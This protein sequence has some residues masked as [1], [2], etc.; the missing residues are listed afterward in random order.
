L[1][2]AVESLGDIPRAQ[3]AQKRKAEKDEVVDSL[4][5]SARESRLRER[6][7][8]RVSGDSGEES[9]GA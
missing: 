1:V 2:D 9:G 4:I 5:A 3:M 8:E 6:E 7:A